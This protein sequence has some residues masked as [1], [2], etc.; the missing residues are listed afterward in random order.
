MTPLRTFVVCMLAAGALPSALPAADEPLEFRA[1]PTRIEV[2]QVNASGV[3]LRLH[4]KITPRSDARLRGISFLDM[5][6]NGATFY[7]APY[8]QP[9]RLRAGEETEL[10][11]FDVELR[12]VDFDNLEPARRLA[13]ESGVRIEGTL[14][15]EV[16]LN[17]VGRLALWSKNIAAQSPLNVWVPFETRQD[18]LTQG[19][20][21]LALTIADPLVRAAARLR[22]EGESWFSDI[23]RIAEPGVELLRTRFELVSKDGEAVEFESLGFGVYDT[24]QTL[25]VPRELLYPWAYD[26]GAAL[27]LR[28]GDLRMRGRVRV[29]I[30]GADRPLLDFGPAEAQARGMECPR[31]KELA[32]NARGKAK[33]M[34]VCR[35]GGVEAVERIAVAKIRPDAQPPAQALPDDEFDTE[36]AILRA[37]P[38]NTGGGRQFEVV[39]LRGRRSG[40]G[41]VL[42]QPLDRSALGSPVLLNGAAVGLFLG[43]Q[44]V[45]SVEAWPK[46]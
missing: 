7:L 13:K 5:R 16:E 32:L 33:A 39:R 38:E 26:P 10:G 37:L 42:L 8:R 30:N 25:L 18:P 41:F 1:E 44:E 36:V 28:R 23:E 19:A 21:D 29:A 35:R 40:D 15:L 12:F 31:M 46:E 20:T 27:A 22:R 45:L 2:A 3:S 11:P 17:W 4:L 14:R 43:G 6:A 34:R 24:P 9:V